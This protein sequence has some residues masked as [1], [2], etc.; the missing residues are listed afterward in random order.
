[1]RHELPLI[2]IKI[3]IIFSLNTFDIKNYNLIIKKNTGIK[4]VLSN[5]S[6]KIFFPIGST[7]KHLSCLKNNIIINK[8]QNVKKKTEM[9]L[10]VLKSY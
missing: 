5:V 1:M 6:N 7:G 9:Q 10:E 3:F 4:L 2:L 8:Q